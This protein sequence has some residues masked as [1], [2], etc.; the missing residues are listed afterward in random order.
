MTRGLL[1]SIP[2]VNKR[3]VH[4]GADNELHEISGVVPNLRDPIVG[5][6]FADRCEMA[7]ERCH[8]EKPQFLEQRDGHFAAC[9]RANELMEA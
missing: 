4:E 1:R 8:A 2:S 6:A 5:C 7:Q 3:L 9:W